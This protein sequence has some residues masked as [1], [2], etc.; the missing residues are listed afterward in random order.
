MTK[1]DNLI[2]LLSQIIVQRKVVKPFKKFIRLWLQPNE[3]DHITLQRIFTKAPLHANV[4]MIMKCCYFYCKCFWTLGFLMRRFSGREAHFQLHDS[5]Y[6]DD[7][8]CI[9]DTSLR[10]QTLVI[11]ASYALSRV[12][13]PILCLHLCVERAFVDS[14]VFYLFYKIGSVNQVNASH[15]T[16]S[17]NLSQNKYIHIWAYRTK[18]KSPACCVCPVRYIMRI[19]KYATLSFLISATTVHGA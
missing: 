15:Y 3:E 12:T 6:S 1:A 13:A 11:W 16:R 9:A 4:W 18:L 5:I 14:F 10:T 7:K 2:A 17:D 19:F 8:Q